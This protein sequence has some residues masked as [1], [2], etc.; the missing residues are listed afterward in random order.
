MGEN[1][2]NFTNDWNGNESVIL[3]NEVVSAQ[4][5]WFGT[6]HV[7]TLEHNGVL[8]TITVKSGVSFTRSIVVKLY[9][10]DALVETKYMGLSIGNSTSTKNTYLIIGVMYIILSLTV[11]SKFFLPIG[12]V[13]FVLG[14]TNTNEETSCNL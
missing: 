11:F 13:F 8:Q 2:I 9:I 1:T 4:F 7:F 3:N 12:I 5:S 10:A 14:L 6:S